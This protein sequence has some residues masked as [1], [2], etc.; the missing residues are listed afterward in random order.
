MIPLVLLV[1]WIGIYPKPL[2]E[3]IEPAV[4]NVITQVARA[5]T[6]EMDDQYSI[7]KKVAPAQA[8]EE[9]STAPEEDGQ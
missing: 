4:K 2:F 3:R 8:T 9:T 1:F 7:R 5:S 6:V